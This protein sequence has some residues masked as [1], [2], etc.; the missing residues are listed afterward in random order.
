[1]PAPLEIRHK[2][3]G[4]EVKGDFVSRT[5]FSLTPIGLAEKGTVFDVVFPEVKKKAR[6][7]IPYN[8]QE[9]VESF[10]TQLGL[11]Y[12]VLKQVFTKILELYSN[13]NS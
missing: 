12:K 11:H 3:I 9:D 8:K 6:V 2:L 4:H 7:Y 10:K 1:M 13:F 5:N